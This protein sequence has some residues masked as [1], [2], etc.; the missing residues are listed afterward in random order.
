MEKIVGQHPLDVVLK[1][2]TVAD[3]LWFPIDSGVSFTNNG[4]AG[5]GSTAAGLRLVR[6]ATGA[7]AS[8]TAYRATALTTGASFSRGKNPDT[9]DWSKFIIIMIQFHV[10]AGSTNGK[11]RATFGPMANDGAQDLDDKGIGF[12][13]HNLALKGYAHGGSGLLTLDLGTAV[14]AGGDTAATVYN[15]IIVSDGAGNVEWFLDGV[16]KG[17]SAAGPTGDSTAGHQEFMVNAEN[18]ADTANNQIDTHQFL[19]GVAQ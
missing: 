7:T 6:A 14:T 8:S 15:M 17:T 4:V 12:G 1:H 11:S 13:L 19:I 9:I 2:V 3:V 16:S 18:N 10:V 5:T